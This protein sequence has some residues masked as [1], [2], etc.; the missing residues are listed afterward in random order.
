MK[1]IFKITAILVLA[2]SLVA[3]SGDKKS[4]KLIVYSNAVSDGRGE[5]LSEQATEAGFDV[6]FVD[7]GGGALIDRVVAEKNNPVANLIIGSNQMGFEK[8]K[9]AGVL[10]KFT[11]DWADLVPEGYNDKDGMYFSFEQIAILMIFNQS[12]INPNAAPKSWPDLISNTAFNGK[13]YVDLKLTGGTI[14]VLISSILSD[15]FDP[16]GELGVSQKGWDLIEAYF[17]NGY[18]SVEGDNFQGLIGSGDVPISRMWSNGMKTLEKEFE[19]TFGVVKPAGGVPFVVEQVGL[20]KGSSNQEG[21]IEF[22]NWFGSVETRTKYAK[23]FGSVP[24]IPEARNTE[25]TRMNEILQDLD[26]KPMDWE[27]ITKNIDKWIEKIE[28]ELRD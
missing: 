25:D 9:T 7:I 28:L 14:Q 1:K 24:V 19:Q 8:L 18:Q 11:P 12:V 21:A 16:N 13:Y 4:E 20:V 23:Q 3:C 2:L 5:W 22:I 6:E 26:Q 15:H 17:A 27:F 10:E